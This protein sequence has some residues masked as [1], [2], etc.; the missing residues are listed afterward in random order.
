MAATLLLLSRSHPTPMMRF[1]GSLQ[2]SPSSLLI[3]ATASATIGTTLFWLLVSFGL[4]RVYCATFCPIGLLSDIPTWIRRA[5]ASPSRPFRPFRFRQAKKIRFPFLF[6][7]V[8][9]LLLC[10]PLLAAILEPWQIYRNMLSPLNPSLLDSTWLAIGA[11]AAT[12]FLTGI[13]SFIALLVWSWFSGRRFCTDICPLGTVMGLASRY[14]PVSIEIDP[15][16]CVNCMKCEQE[17]PAECVKVVSRYVDNT[18]CVRCLECLHVCPANAIGFSTN[19]MRPAT[20][21]MRRVSQKT[22]KTTPPK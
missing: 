18:R 4:G 1:I 19:R 14:S 16:R 6:F 20:P 9:T 21:L 17:C 22:A 3:G 15:D 2:L 10:Q 5:S 13:L 11:P 7:Y 8:L 12:G